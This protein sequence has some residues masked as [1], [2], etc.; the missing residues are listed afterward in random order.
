MREGVREVEGGG[1]RKVNKSARRRWGK[2]RGKT[3]GKR[4]KG[5]RGGEVGDVMRDRT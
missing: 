1:S 3:E 4:G 5:E 2:G